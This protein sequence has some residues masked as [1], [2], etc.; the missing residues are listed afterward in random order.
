M[1]WSLS[2]LIGLAAVSC[3]TDVTPSDAQG[4]STEAS[5][6]QSETSTSVSSGTSTTSGSPTTSGTDTSTGTS[7]STG[8]EPG[9]D[10]GPADSSTGEEDEVFFDDF[11]RQ[12]SAAL[13]NDWVERAPG[14]FELLEG[15]VVRGPGPYRAFRSSLFYRPFSEAILNAEASVEFELN[16]PS[17]GGAPQLHARIQEAGIGVSETLNSYLLFS[18]DPS[19]LLL[20]RT[21]EMDDGVSLATVMIDPPL[22]P[23]RTYRLRLSVTGEDPVELRGVLELLED[24]TGWEELATISHD[25]DAVLRHTSPGS[26]GASSN[27]AAAFSYDNFSITRFP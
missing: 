15:R 3:F 18:N 24:E 13:G 23:Q 27:N 26:F 19:A 7:S 6:S 16:G 1:R 5:T 17:T 12:D 20:E 9:T 25:D 14:A 8:I 22:S 11:R 10:T 4:S 2:G 21:S